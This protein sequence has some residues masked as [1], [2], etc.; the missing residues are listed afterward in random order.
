MN[1]DAMLQIL[2]SREEGDNFS[3]SATFVMNW[4]AV[5]GLGHEHESFKLIL[6]ELSTLNFVNAAL[7]SS[8]FNKAFSAGTLVHPPFHP[9]TLT[10]HCPSQ[11]PG[12]LHDKDNTN[13]SPAMLFMPLS[14]RKLCSEGQFPLVTKAASNAGADDKSRA[15]QPFRLRLFGKDTGTVPSNWPCRMW[16]ILSVTGD[17]DYSFSDYAFN[18]KN[19]K[20]VSFPSKHIGSFPAIV[21]K[22]AYAISLHQVSFPSRTFTRSHFYTLHSP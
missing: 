10:L 12:P 7:V 16:S 4:F 13:P 2:G 20:R 21:A 6:C 15:A 17:D 8:P 1:R 19:Y 11:T 22:N 9:C 18:L 14:C 3:V 5:A